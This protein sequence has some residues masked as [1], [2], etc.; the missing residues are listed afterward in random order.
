MAR[1]RASGPPRFRPSWLDYAASIVLALTIGLPWLLWQ[2]LPAELNAAPPWPAV[3]PA[4]PP[5]LAVTLVGG[6]ALAAV[7]L[8]AARTLLTDDFR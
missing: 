3:L 7:L 2:R 8:A 4:T 5:L 6:T 1:V